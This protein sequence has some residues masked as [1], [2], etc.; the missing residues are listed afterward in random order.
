M[1]APRLMLHEGDAELPVW[2]GRLFDF[3]DDPMACMRRLQSKFGDIAAM[4]EE[5]QRIYF[6][7]SPE[8]NHQ[9]LSD[10]Q[11]F[12]SRFFAL[13]GPRN[14]SQR[15]LTGG[16]LSMNGDQHKRNRRLV[17]DAFIKK[18]IAG[19]LPTIQRLLEELLAEWKPGQERDINRDM[20]EY[21]LRLTSSMLFGV[22]DPEVAYRVGRMIDHWVHLNHELGMGAFVS[23]QDIAQRYEGLLDFAKELEAE[24]QGMIQLRRN[25]GE[26][27]HDVLSALISAHDEVGHISDEEL[28]GQTALM[29]GAAHL[30]TAHTLTWTLFLLAQHP[31]IMSELNE[32]LRRNL[33][34]GFPSLEQFE[35]IPL[36]ER[37]IKESM[38]LM[39]ASSYSQRVT[40]CPTQ[41][42]PFALSTGSAV[43]FSQFMT[44]H[45]PH[46]YPEPEAFR[47]ERWLKITPSPYAYLPFGAG[48]RMCIGGP[49]A[50][51]I[52]KGVLPTILQRFKVTVVPYSEVSAKIVSTMLSPTSS[53]MLRV[54]A[55]DGRYQS[56]PV[57]GNIHTIVDLR[58]VESSLRRAA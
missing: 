47:P 43:I 21:M 12:H 16:L 57:V 18:A 6:I 2:Q 54:D 7:F 28:V 56:H 13:R 40:S 33:T 4:E 39:P 42:G 9:V 35:R 10:G 49:M 26:G 15:R 48:P 41:L 3:P 20:T 53:V 31:S 29:F 55:Q 44:H 24:I 14:S 32:E 58:E 11:T 17:M 36:M 38:R 30:T 37:V 46:L 1:D 19:Y 23:N 52:L 34:G 8:Y 25:K 5:G 50:M 45:L 27:G 22:D 51:L